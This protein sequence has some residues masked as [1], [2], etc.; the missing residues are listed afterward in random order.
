[1]IKGLAIDMD[2]TV[3]KGMNDITVADEFIKR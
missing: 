1:M 2:G 3:Y